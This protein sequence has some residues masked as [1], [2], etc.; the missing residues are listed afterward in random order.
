M[1]SHRAE[2]EP[3]RSTRR[4]PRRRN[5]LRRAAL[6]TAGIAAGAA[7]AV[8]GLTLTGELGTPASAHVEAAPAAD[9]L[10]ALAPQHI[11]SGSAGSR[12]KQ[13]KSASGSEP[14]ANNAGGSARAD[15][16]ASNTGRSISRQ[17]LP[18]CSGKLPAGSAENGRLPDS[19]LCD[20]GVGNFKLRADAAVAFAVMNAA[21]KSDTGKSLCLTDAYRSIA[22]QESARSRKPALAAVPGTSQHGWGIAVDFGCDGQQSGQGVQWNWLVKNSKKYGWENPQW[23]K[24]SKYEPWHFEWAPGRGKK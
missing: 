15:E 4:K 21:Y 7:V 20:I 10:T 24:T 13:D 12:V 1:A 23:A 17:V 18:G 8:G 3:R 22:V 2:T 16:S 19:W 9:A 6:T 5:P 11:G 14:T